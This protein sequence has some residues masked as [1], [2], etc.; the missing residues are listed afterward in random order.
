MS[1]FRDPTLN[2]L[3]TQAL[4]LECGYKDQALY[5]LKD[6]DHEYKGKLY[7]SAKRL[8]L[9]VMDV[10]EYEFAIAY[11]A[12]WDHWV[13]I[14]NNSLITPYAERWAAELAIKVRSKAMSQVINCADTGDRVAA[15]WIVKKEW[16]KRVGRP[17]K[18]AVQ[19]EVD[20]AAQ[21]N[22]EYGADIIRLGT[23]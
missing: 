17:T 8:Y 12:S 18:A 21:A 10:T 15:Q 5:T 23:K 14:R 6:E 11:F 19:R 20:F 4:F 13:R 9:E 7:P 1:K 22:E 16:D 2:R 3:Y